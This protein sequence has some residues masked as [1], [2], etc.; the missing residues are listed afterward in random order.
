MASEAFFEPK[1]ITWG[2][3]FSLG[4]VTEFWFASRPH[5][6]MHRTYIP[7][8][9]FQAHPGNG[10]KKRRTKVSECF[11]SHLV[12]ILFQAAPVKN[13]WPPSCL[14]SALRSSLLRS[15][16]E[17]CVGT[18]LCRRYACFSLTS[19]VS[20]TLSQWKQWSSD[21]RVCLTCSAGPA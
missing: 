5:A 12:W 19:E 1:H 3:R 6:C 11:A 4:M 18:N 17:V 8:R 7:Y 16:R 2:L 10:M 15:D 14:F 9:R 21:R 13:V 20:A